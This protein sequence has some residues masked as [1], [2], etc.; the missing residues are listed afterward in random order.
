MRSLHGSHSM[1][2][3]TGQG[4]FVKLYVGNISKQT[5][6]TQLNALAAQFGTPNNARIAKDKISGHSRGFGFVEF[7]N[8]DEA[9]AAISGLHGKEV[10]GNVL[11]VNESRPKTTLAPST[12][13]T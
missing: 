13:T 7:T 3:A 11:K 2:A 12:A 9:R 8:D 6:D 10:D 5:T 1:A 4:V